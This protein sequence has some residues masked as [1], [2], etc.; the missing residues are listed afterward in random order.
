MKTD[1]LPRYLFEEL[2]DRRRDLRPMDLEVFAVDDSLRRRHVV[3]VRV[4]DRG[5]WSVAIPLE[6]IQGAPDALFIVWIAL[7]YCTL[8]AAP[9]RPSRSF[10]VLARPALWRR[11]RRR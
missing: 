4:R 8:I 5:A 11:D 2:L 6:E 7:Y 1:G 9:R 3:G 10:R